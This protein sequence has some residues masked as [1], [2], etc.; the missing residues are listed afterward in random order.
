MPN[1][2]NPWENMSRYTTWQD[3]VSRGALMRLPDYTLLGFANN[4]NAD[5]VKGPKE[6]VTSAL[7]NFENLERVCAI[8]AELGEE[9]AI[10]ILENELSSSSKAQIYRN[11]I[12]RKYS[13]YKVSLEGVES[14]IMEDGYSAEK[15]HVFWPNFGPPNLFQNLGLE[16]NSAQL[17]TSLFPEMEKFER[18]LLEKLFR[19]SDNQEELLS[20]LLAVF[21]ERV[22]LEET[23]FSSMLV[24]SSVTARSFIRDRI[25]NGNENL[26]SSTLG[27]WTA[28]VR[29]YWSSS[30]GSGI[31]EG[32]DSQFLE[33]FETVR[34]KVASEIQ[35]LWGSFAQYPPVKEFSVGLQPNAYFSDTYGTVRDIRANA[36]DLALRRL[37]EIRSWSIQLNAYDVTCVGSTNSDI[38]LGWWRVIEETDVQ[39]INRPYGGNSRST[40]LRTI[41]NTQKILPEFNWTIEEI[42]KLIQEIT[43]VDAL[44]RQLPQYNQEISNYKSRLEEK[45]GALNF[46]LDEQRTRD[47]VNA[48][49]RAA[50]AKIRA[51]I[52][53]QIQ[54]LEYEIENLQ[55]G[56][57]RSIEQ[58]DNII[59]QYLGESN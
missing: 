45:I 55:L 38:P 3:M 50:R 30:G 19:Q 57:T 9:V 43:V 4:Q 47:R 44:N 34:E 26:F 52:A 41:F 35:N 29:N 13:Y 10:S 31:P 1:D 53:Q 7:L 51:Q 11:K 28:P 32:Y 59:D 24:F 36:T 40:N 48:A 23:D 14:M 33:A 20:S 27:F 56:L 58:R 6:F 15:I 49:A 12:I 39:G 2:V 37:R 16:T 42:D 8:D 46:E 18:P 21:T 17:T 5:W 54:N 22:D 25:F